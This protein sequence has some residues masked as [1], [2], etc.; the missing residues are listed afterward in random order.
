MRLI[1]ISSSSYHSGLL[2]VGVGVVVGVDEALATVEHG[3]HEH[4]QGEHVARDAAYR[5]VLHLGSWKRKS[6]H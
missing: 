2:K 4:A 3:D 1:N 6:A 5:L